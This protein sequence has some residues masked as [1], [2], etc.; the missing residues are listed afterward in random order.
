MSGVPQGSVLGPILFLLYITVLRRA[1]ES[2]RRT[3]AGAEAVGSVDGLS[4]AQWGWGVGRGLLTFCAEIMH[5]GALLTGI[6][7]IS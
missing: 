4:P 6:C 5:F 2:R 7:V 3:T 1:A